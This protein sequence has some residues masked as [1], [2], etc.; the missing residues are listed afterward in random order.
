MPAGNLGIVGLEL[1]KVGPPF[2]DSPRIRLGDPLVDFRPI[3]V[4]IHDIDS[5][6]LAFRNGKA[7]YR[8][9]RGSDEEERFDLHDFG[10]WKQLKDFVMSYSIDESFE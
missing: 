6:R 7:E 1:Q 5:L 9:C 2:S 4:A 3:L 8:D 10:Y